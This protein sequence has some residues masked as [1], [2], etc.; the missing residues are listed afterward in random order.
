M[1]KL[2][3]GGAEGGEREGRRVREL[4]E[5]VRELDERG[6]GGRER[7]RDERVRTLKR[8]TTCFAPG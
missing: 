8:S 6:E 2:A 5:T 1:R 3:R 7:E 4:D